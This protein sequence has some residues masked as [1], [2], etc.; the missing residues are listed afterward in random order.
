MKKQ[1]QIKCKHKWE[2]IVDYAE[3]LSK[4]KRLGLFHI[5]KK[6]KLRSNGE[7]LT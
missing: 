1:N 5:C 4:E 7:I 2:H 6:C 3:T